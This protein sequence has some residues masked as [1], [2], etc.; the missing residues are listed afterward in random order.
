MK[1]KAIVCNASQEF[2]LQDVDLA[3]RGPDD[4]LVRALCSGLSI[5]TETSVYRGRLNWGPFPMVAGYQA[6][7]VIEKAG[8]NVK[9]YKPGDTVYYRSQKPMKGP[10]GE[11]IT[12][13]SGTHVSHAVINVGKNVGMGLLPDGA[14]IVAGSQFVTAA[15]GLYGVDMSNPRMGDTVV[16]HGLGL[17]GLS[18]VA[19][20]VHR[21]CKVIA[22][23]LQEN[24]LEVAK[25]FGA[26]Y[27]F[28]AGKVD[29]EKEVKSIVP[30]GADVVY[31][32]TGI[33][34]L[35][36]KALPLARTFGKYVWEGNYGKDPISMHFLVPHGHQL[37]MFFPCNDGLKPCREAVLRNMAMGTLKWN[38]TITHVIEP[39]K[40]AAL[41]DRINKNQEPS[42]IGVVVRWSE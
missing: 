24:R 38:E 17:I 27:A 37:Q 42:A 14:P 8:E 28:N 9:D 30:S 12:P 39:E 7:G 31:E 15:V 5:G 33:P 1:A 23:D 40:A 13:T 2:T 32:A 6:I 41:F 19:A 10:D 16:V 35:I 29:V 20:C 36:D 34:A 22:V 4:V 3:D 11:T 26:D 21:G 18:V 25:S